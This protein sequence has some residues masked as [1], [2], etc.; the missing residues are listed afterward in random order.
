M[1]AQNNGVRFVTIG[2]YAEL[3]GYSEAAIREKTQDGTWVEG[4]EWKWAPD[5]RKMIDV[6]GAQA[7]CLKEGKVSTRGRK[8]SEP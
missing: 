7:W 5:G 3:S 1:F 2:R 4:R 6:E 8:R